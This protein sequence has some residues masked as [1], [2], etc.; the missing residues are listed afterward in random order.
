MNIFEQ[1]SQLD[2]TVKSTRGQL[3]VSQLWWA[4]LQTLDVI[5]QQ[6]N[7]ELKQSQEE[8]FIKPV[9]SGLIDNNTLRLEILKHIIKHKLAEKDAAKDA[10]LKKQ[11]KEALL[12][13]LAVK[14][15]EELGKLSKQ[16]ILAQLNAL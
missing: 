5:A 9:V 2:L 13:I 1:A 4:S 14:E 10:Q 12:G 15:A 6:V 7:R 16:D 8:S 3:S 11:K